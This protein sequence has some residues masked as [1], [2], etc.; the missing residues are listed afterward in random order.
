MSATLSTPGLFSIF[1]KSFSA[2]ALLVACCFLPNDAIAQVNNATENTVQDV[3]KLRQEIVAKG[4]NFLADKGQAAD[5]SFTKRAGAG[6]TA[7]AVTSA[8]RNG[9]QPD[10]PL[11][12][13]GLKALESFVKPDGGIYG[14]GRLKNY[15]TCVATVAFAE[16][17]KDG[18][19]D[20][21]LANAQN[22]LKGLQVGNGENQKR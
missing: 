22:F 2:A 1:V 6:I 11:V 9:K 14:G 18:K 12:A 13:K 7:L 15:E 3:E 5:G 8:L 4:L 16:A 19:Y 17:N 20:K 21:L 10:D